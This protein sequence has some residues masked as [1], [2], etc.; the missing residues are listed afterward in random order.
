M[1]KIND[2]DAS[3]QSEHNGSDDEDDDSYI[4]GES[5]EDDIDEVGNIEE[6]VVIVD[7][8]EEDEEDEEDDEDDDVNHDINTFSIPFGNTIKK[9]SDWSD[10]DNEVVEDIV[11]DE[12]DEDDSDN[13]ESDDDESDDDTIGDNG[14]KITDEMRQNILNKYHPESTVH[15]REE[16]YEL[17]QVTRDDNNIIMDKNHRTVPILTKYEKTKILGLR[18]KQI[19]NGATPSIELPSILHDENESTIQRLQ[20]KHFDGYLVALEELKQKTIPIIIRRPLP[21]GRSEYWRLQD[22]EVYM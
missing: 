13:D 16:I 20:E 2:D 1:S 11:G 8:D 3:F 12:L 5:D 14:E 9:S 19:N 6:E 10:S 21:N 4:S 15:S 17:C 22:L 7:D 18:A